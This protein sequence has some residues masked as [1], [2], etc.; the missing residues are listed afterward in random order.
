MNQR[1]TDG[2][3]IG[4]EVSLFGYRK[5]SSG[6]EA[7]LWVAA[8]EV[9]LQ[10]AFQVAESEGHHPDLAAFA[11]DGDVAAGEVEILELKDPRLVLAERTIPRSCIAI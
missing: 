4:L 5:H 8:D 1:C 3:V 2:G 6:S 9:D 11:V 10:V 7:L